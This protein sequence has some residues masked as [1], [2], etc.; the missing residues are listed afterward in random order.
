M[1]VLVAIL[2]VIWLALTRKGLD[3]AR[4]FTANREPG[5]RMPRL[6]QTMNCW[7]WSVTPIDYRD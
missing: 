7:R 5:R 1:C 6:S 2:A 4:H 3:K